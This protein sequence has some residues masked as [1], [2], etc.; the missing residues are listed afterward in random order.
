MRG[1][2]GESIELIALRDI[3][4]DEELTICYGEL[5][6]DDFLLD[7]GFLPPYPNPCDTVALA[8]G[9]GQLLQSACAAVGIDANLERWQRE[10]LPSAVPEGRPFISVTPSGLDRSA[11]AACRIAAA[12]DE[13]DL[14]DADGGRRPLEPAGEERAMKL[15]AA[16]VSIALADLPQVHTAV[17]MTA[18]AFALPPLHCCLFTAAFARRGAL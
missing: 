1:Q 2:L 16:M 11:M 13:V 3:E 10:A 17:E 9:D 18:A 5:S 14:D 15:A 7:F 8:W 6:N 4:P 12:A